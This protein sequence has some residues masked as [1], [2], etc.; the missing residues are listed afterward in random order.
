MTASV[1]A[2]EPSATVQWATRIYL[3]LLIAGFALIPAYLIAY[4]YVFQNPALF[5]ENHVF[6]EFAIAA[7]TLE[8]LFVSYVA[9]R[10]YQSS[11]EPLLRWLT[12]GFLAFVLIY[13]LHGA[14]TGM[15]HH[16]IWL[17]L[18]YGPASRLAMSVLLLVAL[19]TWHQPPDPVHLRREPGRWLKWIVLF[20][21][22]DVAVGVLAYSPIAGELAV[23]L[24][25]EGGAL[26]FSVVNLAVMLARRIRSP[27]MKIFGI[28][29]TSFA[30]SSLAFILARPWNHLWWL[31]HAIFAAG[32]FLLSYGVVQA[33]RT[34]RS[35]ATIYSQEELMARIAEEMERTEN[36]LQEL[37]RTNLK[38]EHLAATDPLTG[39]A[40]R[41]QFIGMVE[42]EI[43]RAKRG[44]APFSLLALDLDH[45]KAINDSY[46]HQVGD[47]ILRGFVQRCLEAIRPYDGVAR[48]GGEEFMVLL[49]QVVLS[50]GQS[51][52]ERIRE[53]IANGV[54]GGQSGNAV[55][56]T[57]SIGVSQFGRDGDTIDEILRAADERLYR[58]KHLGRN[59]VIGA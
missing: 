19:L 54:F 35:F 13:A 22:I 17:F 41:R 23:R 24:S 50:V 30:L 9:W 33:F 51:I 11:G 4:V 52:G 20:A 48:V 56:L 21:L 39:A 43:G 57:V 5:F 18:L 27:L 1:V 55:A 7:A 16:N 6:H 45:F 12:L 42:A 2:D 8:G 46:G 40:N 3:G 53:A 10:C 47:E 34:T 31:A 44:G 32:F 37:K 38:L 59:R 49:P 26:V 28:S 15:A 36:A 14:F 25:L 29:V 58:A